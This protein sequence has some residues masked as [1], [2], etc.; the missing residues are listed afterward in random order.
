MLGTKT[1]DPDAVVDFS[2]DWSRWLNG[3]EISSATWTVP[4]GATKTEEA[5]TATVTTVWLSGGTEG[6]AYRISVRITTAAGRTTDESF[7]IAVKS[8]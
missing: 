1:K 5:M 8:R 7:E 6:R 3:D 4:L 2:V